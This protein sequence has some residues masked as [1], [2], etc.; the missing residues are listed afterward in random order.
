MVGIYKIT[1]PSKKV[2]IGQSI[3]IYRR[4]S[5]YKLKGCPKQVK[6]HSSFLK[7]GYDSHIFEVSHELPIDISQEI[8]NCYESIYLESYKRTW[9]TSYEYKKCW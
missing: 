2:Y 4:W 3:N 6:L 7:Y 9:H 1:S 5:S 8:L